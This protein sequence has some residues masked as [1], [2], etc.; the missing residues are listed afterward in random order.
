MPI[1]EFQCETCQH[2]FEE[3]VMKRDEVITCP[4][5]GGEHARKLMSS[6]AVTGSARLSGGNSCGSCSASPGKCAG[7]GS[8]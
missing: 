6:F 1:Y 8:R 3:L 2:E 7:C 4:S 5:C